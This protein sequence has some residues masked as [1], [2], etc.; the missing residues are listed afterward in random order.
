ML[1]T[2]T[3]NNIKLEDDTAAEKALWIAVLKQAI[4]DVEAL[5]EKVQNDPSLW[6]E[7]MFRSEVFHIKKYFQCQSMEPGGFGFICDLIGVEPDQA[8]K[9]I[10]GKYFQH[11]MPVEKRFVRKARFIAA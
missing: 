8:A 4:D 1:S 11:L 6:A 2:K 9:S 5:T 3:S 7:H 10:E